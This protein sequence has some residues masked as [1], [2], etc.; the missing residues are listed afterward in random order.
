MRSKQYMSKFPGALD[1]RDLLRRKTTQK[2]IAERMNISAYTMSIKL[3][4]PEYF[5][6]GEMEMLCKA[7]G[8]SLQ[9][10]IKI[11]KEGR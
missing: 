8:M 3:R 11:L 6:L 5:T 2:E 10:G 7:A 1:F 9:D 4:K